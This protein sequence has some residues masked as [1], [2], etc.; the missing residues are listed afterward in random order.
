MAVSPP[1]ISSSVVAE[2]GSIHPVPVAGG[3]DQHLAVEGVRP[4]Q[5][6]H[7]QVGAL[8]EVVGGVDAGVDADRID[9]VGI[10]VADRL[11][12]PPDRVSVRG[13]ATNVRPSKPSV[14]HAASESGLPDTVGESGC[15]TPSAVPSSTAPN[16]RFA[17]DRKPSLTTSLNNTQP[18]SATTTAVMTLDV[19]GTRTGSRG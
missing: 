3:D 8:V 11:L 16:V 5:L 13:L 15:S 19:A 12:E 18:R 1:C 10:A 7:D 4:F 2:F 9:N 14:S 6:L 17:H